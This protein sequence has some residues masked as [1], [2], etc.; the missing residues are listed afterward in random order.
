M[1]QPEAFYFEGYE[2]DADA[3]QV[4]LR[5]SFDQVEHF[6]H[7]VYFDF[8]F[9][10]QYHKNALD[11]VL[12][13][14]WLMAGVSYYKLW[15]PPKIIVKGTELS[16]AEAEFFSETYRLGLGQLC[17][18]NQLSLS[19]VAVFEGRGSGGGAVDGLGEGGDLV[20]LGGGKDSLVSTSIME[21]GGCNF[22]TFS[23]VYSD[24]AGRALHELGELVCRPFLAMRRQFDPRMLELNQQGAYNGHVP[25]TA[26]IMFIG[27]AAAVLSGRRRVIFSHEASAGEGNVEYEGVEINHQY[28]KSLAFEQAIRGHVQE[29]LSPDLDVFSLLRP[30]GELRITE[31]F[32]KGPMERFWGHFTS[33]NRSFRHGSSGFTWCGECPKCAFMFLALAVFVP[34]EKVVGMWGENLLTKDSLEPTYRE[35]LGLTGHKPFECVGEIEECRQAVRMLEAGGAYPEVRRFGVPEGDYDWKKWHEDDMPSDY[36]RLVGNFVTKTEAPA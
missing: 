8:E 11:R 23:A 35:L 22:A 20:A 13:S 31:L 9:D 3:K 17:Y 25:V 12:R 4:S 2:F 28:S 32:A 24:E 6:T 15:M 29:S 21:A 18:E 10:S 26:E 33:C 34:K 14:L 30:L 27:L 5:Y 7:N 16:Q 19:R 36:R 1:K